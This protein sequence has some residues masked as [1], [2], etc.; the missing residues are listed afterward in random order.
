MKQNLPLRDVTRFFVKVE[1]LL[2]YAECGAASHYFQD[3]KILEIFLLV[4]LYCRHVF[5]DTSFLKAKHD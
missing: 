1:I 4:L 5:I 3:K 2:T